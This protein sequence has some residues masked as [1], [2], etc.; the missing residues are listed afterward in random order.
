M[1]N[2]LTYAQWAAIAT[3]GMG[4]V[5]GLSF[6]LKWGFRFRLVGITG[7]MGVL[8]VG[9]FAL[10]VVPFTRTS[11]PG[12]V[13]FSTVYDSGAAQV[14]ITVSNEITE[15]QLTAT[16]QQAASDLFSPGRLSRGEDKLTIRARTV[17]HPEPGVSEPLYL[18]QVRR[19]LFVRDDE[20]MD[21]KLYP[22]SLAKLPQPT[23][24]PESSAN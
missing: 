12:A 22:E 10:G 5:T 11:I 4:V 20:D 21:I 6:L 14:V 17:L 24:E 13:R 3:V 7:F 2:F 23:V 16:L 9:L 15:E 1:D 19:S 8:T 18:G